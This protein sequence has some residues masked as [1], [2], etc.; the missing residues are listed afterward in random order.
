MKLPISK[1]ELKKLSFCMPTSVV[2]A[3]TF[4]RILRRTLNK[5]KQNNI[6]VVV[7]YLVAN[8]YLELENGQV[9][10]TPKLFYSEVRK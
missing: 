6:S 7:S 8:G 2:Y 4:Y 5:K 1:V 3:E 9:R 10:A